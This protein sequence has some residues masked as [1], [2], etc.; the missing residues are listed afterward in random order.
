V[1]T[2]VDT[3][4]LLDL[5][6]EDAANHEASAAALRK[7]LAEGALVA[8]DVVWAE[9]ALPF[10]DRASFVKAMETLGVAFS[11]MHREAALKASE[12]W[13][14]YRKRGGTRRRMAPD[15]LVGA[16]ALVQGDRL[17][18]R[19]R[20]FYRDYVRHPAIL[21]PTAPVR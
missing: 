3:N 18:T 8:C 15:F 2:A 17:L 12:S 1:I 5:F 13:R 6:W 7:C 14:R 16:H 19:D 4:V 9:A 20:V 11:P 10:P 21:D